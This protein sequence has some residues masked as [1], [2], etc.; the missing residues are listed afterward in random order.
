MSTLGQTGQI[1]VSQAAATL[2]DMMASMAQQ[3]MDRV[4]EP[5]IQDSIRE[6]RMVVIAARID[7]QEWV[8]LTTALT[9]VCEDE[10]REER[11]DLT[12]DSYHGVD[13]D[14]DAWRIEVHA[15]QYGPAYPVHAE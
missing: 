12:I 3:M 5:A 1:V 8:G 13:D 4:V 2:E 14:G 7:S 15:S 10:T 6:T 9:M 11:P